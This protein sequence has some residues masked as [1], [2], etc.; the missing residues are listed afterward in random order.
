[1]GFASPPS[2]GPLP[3]VGRPGRD[4]PAYRS[5]LSEA[6]AARFPEVSVPQVFPGS[7][8]PRSGCSERGDMSSIVG[9][10]LVAFSQ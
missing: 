4:H 5:V 1:M 6:V 2:P 8:R 9:K 10:P 7:S 3:V